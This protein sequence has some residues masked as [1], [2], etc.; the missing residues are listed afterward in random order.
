MLKSKSSNGMSLVIVVAIGE[1][2]GVRNV[3][4]VTYSRRRSQW[5]VPPICELFGRQ[6]LFRT[7]ANE[8]D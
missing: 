6:L 4:V 8:L 7:M 3:H 5:G 1:V 2:H